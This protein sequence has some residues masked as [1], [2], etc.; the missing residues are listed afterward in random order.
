LA[1]FALTSVFG[2]DGLGSA[3][4]LTLAEHLKKKKKKKNKKKKQRTQNKNK[5]KTQKQ[6]T[7][8]CPRGA[9]LGGSGG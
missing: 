4:T 2:L 7:K 5:N 3:G 6:K 9:L 1:G 8:K